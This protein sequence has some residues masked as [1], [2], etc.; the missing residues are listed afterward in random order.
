MMTAPHEVIVR[1]A[2]PGDAPFISMVQRAAERPE[3]RRS[4]IDAAMED[5]QRLI[6]VGM[7]GGRVV[8]WAKTH[9][10]DRPDANAPAGHYLGGVTVD[11]NSRRLGVGTALTEARL[12]WIWERSVDAWYVVNIQNTA[13]IALHE[14]WGFEEVARAP[15]FHTTAFSGG[16]GILLRARARSVFR[17]NV[18]VTLG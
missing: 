3:F 6:M 12:A 7:V 8:G 10:W 15:Q 11:P 9:H 4:A 14:R 2:T 5:A 18:T 17:H 16:T 1:S 13:S